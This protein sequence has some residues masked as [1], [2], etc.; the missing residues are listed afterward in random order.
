MVKLR[1][2]NFNYWKENPN[3]LHISPVVRVPPFEKH[4]NIGLLHCSG[5]DMRVHSAEVVDH[6]A[7]KKR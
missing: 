6:S 3:F 5:C 1:F 4:C 2:I 7:C